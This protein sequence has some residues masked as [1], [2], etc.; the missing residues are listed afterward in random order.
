MFSDLAPFERDPETV[1]MEE[2]DRER[3][4]TTLKNSVDKIIMENN[5]IKL[6][7]DYLGTSTFY[8]DTAKQSIWEVVWM[9]ASS[10]TNPFR[11]PSWEVAKHIAEI[12]NLAVTADHYVT[13]KG[14]LFGF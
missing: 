6:K 12:N 1:R 14:S 2:A 13:Q 11:K 9:P 3:R 10:S 7:S 5:F 8:Y 4:N